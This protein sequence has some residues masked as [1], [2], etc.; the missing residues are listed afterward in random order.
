MLL[1]VRH[2]SLLAWHLLLVKSKASIRDH[3]RVASQ[4]SEA[5][6]CEAAAMLLAACGRAAC[7]IAAMGLGHPCNTMRKRTTCL[8]RLLSEE[9]PM[10]VA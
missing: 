7:P 10:D 8:L 2:L 4:D 3:P 9:A 5:E 1:L 6:I